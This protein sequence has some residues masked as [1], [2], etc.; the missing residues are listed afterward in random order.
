MD[1]SGPRPEY[2]DFSGYT[3]TARPDIRAPVDNKATRSPPFDAA[4]LFVPDRGSPSHGVGFL[5]ADA[6]P[7]ADTRTYG[8]LLGDGFFKVMR[9]DGRVLLPAYCAFPTATPGVWSLSWNVTSDR[10]D[11]FP[12]TLR[13]ARGSSST[14]MQN[15]E[16]NPCRI[17]P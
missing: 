1:K 16:H 15:I 17:L 7:A 10:Q 6:A 2:A 4:T 12:V 13:L 3:F 14:P 8:F 5:A 11:G 9:N